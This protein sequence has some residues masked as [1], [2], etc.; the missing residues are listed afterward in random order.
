MYKLFSIIIES[1][2]KKLGE[3]VDWLRKLLTSSKSAVLKY[4]LSTP[5]ANHPKF[6]TAGQVAAAKI[7][8][9]LH[10]SCGS[11]VQIEINLAKQNGVPAETI[12]HIAEENYDS[13]SEEISLVARFTDAVLLRNMEEQDLRKNIIE[14]HGEHILSEISLAIATAQFHPTVKR[15]MG[16]GT[17]C[18]NGDLKY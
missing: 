3:P 4:F 8:T 11:C 16:Y 17:V 6:A 15:A 7:R 2:E 1:A 10:E 13:L 5:L 14:M 12:K 18:E 9:V